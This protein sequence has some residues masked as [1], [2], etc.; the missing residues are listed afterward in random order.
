MTQLKK[1]IAFT[2]SSVTLYLEGVEMGR[3]SQN[4]FDEVA[5]IVDSNY[6]MKLTQGWVILRTLFNSAMSILAW[7]PPSALAVVFW[8][9]VVSPPDA[10]AALQWF[11]KASSADLQHLTKV[12][13]IGLGGICILTAVLKLAIKGPGYF[14]YYS[15][16]NDILFDRLRIRSVAENLR[17]LPSK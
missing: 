10:Q 7:L 4:S 16:R 13:S 3:L 2:G 15:V 17:D 6:S 1:E 14:G 8:L 11:M 12:M 5:A 9:T